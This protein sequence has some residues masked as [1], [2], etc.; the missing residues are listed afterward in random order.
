[1]GATIGCLLLGSELTRDATQHGTARA[2]TKAGVRRLAGQP[3]V[4]WVLRRASD[5]QQL[6]GLVVSATPAQA[7]TSFREALPGN[8]L[9][10]VSEAADAWTRLLDCHAWLQHQRR[11]AITGFVQLSLDCPF[12]DPCLLDRLV[13]SADRESRADYATFRSARNDFALHSQIGLMAEY[14][15]VEALRRWDGLAKSEESRR[16]PGQFLIGRP[17]EFHVRLLALPAM[18]DRDDLRL[19]IRHADDWDHAEQIVEALGLE[20]LEWQ[21]IVSLL[22][23]Q[24]ALRARMAVLNLHE[25]QGSRPSAAAAVV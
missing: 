13:V 15:R 11:E 17:D 23:S 25:R 22:D 10:H 14:L 6:A 12:V 5:A 21:R 3:L 1:M 7:T 18:L 24:P 8:V 2:E 20:H 9:L 16:D 4:H 19:S